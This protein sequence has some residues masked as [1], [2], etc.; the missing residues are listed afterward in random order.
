[1]AV[2]V[3][4]GGRCGNQLFH[5]AC[6]RFVQ[7]KTND[8]H[9]IL[10][11]NS[12]F[13]QNKKE[14]GWY[15]VLE[16]F[17]TV[18]YVYYDKPGTVLKNETTLVEKIPVL[19]KSFDVWINRNRSREERAKKAQRFQSVLNRFNVYWVREGVTRLYPIRGRNKSIITGNCESYE[20]FDEIGDILREELQPVHEVEERNRKLIDKITRTNSI[21]ISVRRGDFFNTQ[22]EKS[23]GVCTI[24]YYYDAVEIMKNKIEAPVFFVFSDDIN[25]CKENLH[26]NADTEYVS[27]DMPVYETLRLMYSCKHFIISNST[28]SWWGQYLSRNK[29]KIVVSPSRWN[30]DGFNSR[31]IEKK[32]ILIDVM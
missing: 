10:N 9:L 11:F 14:L 31:L 17:N 29:E 4:M 32:W 24:K 13:A 16:D 20:I 30:N 26:F 8:K 21:C 15:D 19:L 6:A 23:F 12:I 27:Q 7:I 2:Y 18:P 22:F 3:E 28:F 1:M 25:W 5:Y